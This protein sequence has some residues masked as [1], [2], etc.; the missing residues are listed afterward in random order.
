MNAS[1]L[2]Q[3]L[4]YIKKPTRWTKGIGAELPEAYKKFWKEW[5]ASPSAVHYIE[6][7]GK[8]ERN[9]ETEEV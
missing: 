6:K 9:E 1:K 8:Y 3:K 7:K 5:K 4:Y 2:L